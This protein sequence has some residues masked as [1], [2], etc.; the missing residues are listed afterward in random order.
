M[1]R[2]ALPVSWITSSLHISTDDA[3]RAYAQS[4]STGGST[5]FGVE[6]L[7]VIALF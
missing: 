5:V 6:F 3:E 2:Y 1:I 7:S 4:Y